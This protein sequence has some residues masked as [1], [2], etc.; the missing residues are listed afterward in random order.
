[1]P[2]LSRPTILSRI[3]SRSVLGTMLLL[4]ILILGACAAATPAATPAPTPSQ[5]T[6]VPIA[7]STEVDATAV[8]SQ[9][10]STPT[11]VPQEQPAAPVEPVPDLTQSAEAA[12]VTVEVTPLTLQDVQAATLDFEIT[13]STHA[14]ELAYDL[15]QIVVLRDDQGNEYRPASWEGPTGGHHVAGVLR[16]ADRATILQSGVTKVE[17]DLQGIADV[18]SRLF[19]WDVP[20]E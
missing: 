4:G 17:L 9:E 6:S 13:L 3:V 19:R 1:M 14:V 7:V 8:P 15:T 10:A 18:P 5:A 16:F 20:Q 11:A 2:T 12:S